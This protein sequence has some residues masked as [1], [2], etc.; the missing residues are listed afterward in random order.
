LPSPGARL[1]RM[2]V[3]LLPRNGY[4]WTAYIWLI[5][6]VTPVWY[7]ASGS[8]H[9]P[10][11]IAATTAAIALF[12]P[13]YFWGCW[14][15][16]RAILAPIAG[17]T[18]IACAICPVNPGGWTF[19]VYASWF[20]GP[21]GRPWIGVRILAG[22]LAIVGMEAWMV[23]LRPVVWGPA[24]PLIVLVGGLSVV[25]TEIGRRQ[26]ALRR[27]A[28]EEARRLAVVAER[29]R[30]GRDLHDVLGHTLTV[31]T[32]KA[33]LAS[34]LMPLDPERSRDEIRDVERISREALAEVRRAVAGFRGALMAEEVRLARRALEAAGVECE[35]HIAPVALGGPEE[36][37]LALAVREAVTN[38]IRHARAHRCVVRLDGDDVRTRLE[39][40]DDGVG[41]RAPD[42]SGLSGMRERMSGLG[43]GLTREGSAGTRLTITLP[44]TGISAPSLAVK[45]T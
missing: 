26:A 20:S 33:E 34:K 39:I 40:E 38:V 45:A 21:A 3:R 12:L 1:L 4:S 23:R 15:T 18:A 9:A 16:G 19:F 14:L 43:G 13:L 37:A 22:L 30:I 11:R 31:I 8:A 25:F 28:E 2:P 7:A 17:I 35:F 29:E 10:W 41:G 44:A 5:Y 36:H 24:V 42:G 6:L 32:L 27:A